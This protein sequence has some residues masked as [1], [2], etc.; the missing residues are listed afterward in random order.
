M[1]VPQLRLLYKERGIPFAGRRLKAELIAGLQD[2]DRRRG[3]APVPIFVQPPPGAGLGPTTPPMIRLPIQPM[4]PAGQ[5]FQLQPAGARPLGPFVPVPIGTLPPA[6]WLQPAPVSPPRQPIP[7]VQ[8]AAPTR[9]VPGARWQEMMGG[10]RRELF[11]ANAPT[12]PY[13]IGLFGDPPIVV[14][15][16]QYVRR[17]LPNVSP[18]DQERLVDAVVLQA[19]GEGIT[20]FDNIA[21]T[22][23]LERGTG[24]AMI[25]RAHDQLRGV[26]FQ[27]PFTREQ[28]AAKVEELYPQVRQLPL[29]RQGALLNRLMYDIETIAWDRPDD[30][31][32][33]QHI[34]VS[35][36]EMIEDTLQ[37]AGLNDEIRGAARATPPAPAARLTDRRA[38]I[39]IE[40][41]FPDLVNLT[42]AQ[43][44]L[45]TDAVITDAD[46]RGVTTDVQFRDYLLA[47]G[48]NFIFP[49]MNDR[50]IAIPQAPAGQGGAP[51]LTRAN[52]EA[53]LEE[54]FPDIRRLDPQA[55]QALVDEV[56]AQ[57]RNAGVGN[58][59]DFRGFLEVELV[60]LVGA[61]LDQIRQQE[62][63][64][65][66]ALREALNREIAR[67]AQGAGQ[68]VPNPAAVN[69]IANLVI[70]DAVRQGVRTGQE[71]VDFLQ[72]FR[73]QVFRDELTRRGIPIGPPLQFRVEQMPF[74][75]LPQAPPELTRERVGTI[76][77]ETFPEVQEL[78]Q[79]DFAALVDHVRTRALEVGVGDEADLHAFL[80]NDGPDLVGIFINQLP[81]QPL[82]PQPA[83]VQLPAP[84]RFVLGPA[85]PNQFPA[86]LAPVPIQLA[87]LP[88]GAAPT[89]I[90]EI[91]FAEPTP[92]LGLQ[93]IY[94]VIN[95]FLVL[96][97]PALSVAG[98][99]FLEQ[100]LEQR[101][102]RAG[103][104][105][106]DAA[107]QT[108]LR[109]L[110]P[111]IIEDR[112]R[113]WTRTGHREFFNPEQQPAPIV[114]L[115]QQAPLRV[116]PG[117][118][119]QFVPAAQLE[120]QR[121]PP[122]NTLEEAAITFLTLHY[123][124]LNATGIRTVALQLAA[125][126][127]G[128]P[129]G[130]N[131][132]V[133]QLWM[134][135][136]GR[137][138][139]EDLVAQRQAIWGAQARLEQLR[140]GR[141]APVAPAQLQGPLD[142]QDII[143][144]IQQFLEREYPMFNRD[145]R[146]RMAG[147]LA[148]FIERERNFI[149]TNQIADWLNGIG[150]RRVIEGH[151]A[152][153]RRDGQPFFTAAAGRAEPPTRAQITDAIDDFLIRRYPEINAQGRI[154]LALE[155][156]P[157][158]LGANET[159]RRTVAAI[160][161]WLEL[162]GGQYIRGK[163]VTWREQNDPYFVAG[164][165]VRQQYQP[166]PPATLPAEV[167]PQQVME[168]IRAFDAD[169]PR[170]EL[171]VRR[172]DV[173]AEQTIPQAQLTARH[174]AEA[175]KRGRVISITID[176][177]TASY[178]AVGYLMTEALPEFI[179]DVAKHLNLTYLND[180]IDVFFNIFWY[181]QQAS[182]ARVMSPS[183]IQYIS[184]LNVDLLKQLLPPNYQGS[185]DRASLLAAL[186]FHARV[187][188]GGYTPERY[189]QVQSYP[190]LAVFYLAQ[191][192]Y[193]D[194]ERRNTNLIPPYIT[195]A[196]N[197]ASRMEP[198]YAATNAQNINQ[199]AERFQLLF[200][201]NTVNVYRRIY[202][203][204]GFGPLYEDF[205]FRTVG[206]VGR[207][208]PPPPLF[209]PLDPNTFDEDVANITIR[210][211]SDR[212]LMDGYEPFE[213][214]DFADRAELL[215]EI[216][217]QAREGARGGAVWT[218]RHHHCNNDDLED[219]IEL[220]PRREVDKN[221]PQN[222]SLS[223]G[224]Q[225]NYRCY[226]MDELMANFNQD[227]DGIFHFY[228]PDWQ[229]DIINPL[230]GQPLEREFPLPAIR[231]LRLL[232]E[233]LALENPVFQPLQARVIE[234]LNANNQAGITMRQLRA[235]Y[236]TL[237]LAD[238][239]SVNEYFTLLFFIGMYLR[240]WNGPGHPY[241]YRIAGDDA[242]RCDDASRD[243][244]FLLYAE[245]RHVLLARLDRANQPLAAWFRALPTINYDW[246][247]GTVRVATPLVGAGR[248]T[249]LLEQ[250]F[251]LL[252]AGNFCQMHGSDIM[253]GSGFFL[254]KEVLEL[255]D[256]TLFNN[257]L[258]QQ[259]AVLNLA[260]AQIIPPRIATHQERIREAKAE[261]DRLTP[262]VN[263]LAIQMTGLETQIRAARTAGQG[264]LVNQLD[265][266]LRELRQQSFA[267]AA[268]R[269]TAKEDEER[270]EAQLAS[271]IYRYGVAVPAQ[272]NQALAMLREMFRTLRATAG[273]K[274]RATYESRIRELGQIVAG[275]PTRLEDFN[276]ARMR[277]TQ[278]E[279]PWNPIQFAE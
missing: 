107:I 61:A 29:D 136:A 182:N 54:T 45:I 153:W 5:Q 206:F 244:N 273:N 150:R 140:G 270:E 236:R 130:Q 201:V 224:V 256:P 55:R 134:G 97:Y 250:V 12:A 221:N 165:Q 227:A 222:P 215:D 95:N 196:R 122:I 24:R 124:I 242:I 118:M 269:T 32:L 272:A 275:N 163:I 116:I 180:T 169:V 274:L 56:R 90:R 168:E 167:G 234:G 84:R 213:L 71:M 139:I 243:G 190:S 99:R 155:L 225:R 229:I 260:L 240:H 261:Y 162:F 3:V 199:L 70:P 220:I 34:E 195:V 253:L 30:D 166:G 159:Y 100:D 131:L 266:R 183:A 133:F 188:A 1:L 173:V 93:D 111:V 23:F 144:Q 212:E 126:A 132:E 96:R 46:R 268:R 78:R 43:Q 263:E 15:T 152:E 252:E 170:A 129:E 143:A 208:P 259:N 154:I 112:I 142:R 101:R 51:Q 2:D 18:Q 68:A 184:R 6:P 57:A 81:A 125:R 210:G 149:T 14:T 279:D 44:D 87:R 25:D 41:A 58:E 211:Y 202:Y 277:I 232:L 94:R 231:T 164:A 52:V 146:F 254:I 179:L 85:V 37:R 74:Q 109:T 28:V 171:R 258:R 207:Y 48:A 219:P 39:L 245:L 82:A 161:N 156:V 8:P 108:W 147:I 230:T 121:N 27:T 49:F 104:A 255:R 42:Q 197:P 21:H 198:V 38:W 20:D 77:R 69:V 17:D 89:G 86:Q 113:E 194:Q 53:V 192:Y 257:F 239:Q 31:A 264:Q 145:G 151:I 226:L 214:D 127:H 177:Q 16:R 59:D 76:L 120:A 115:G 64:D 158:I 276:P 176:G 148:D 103:I 249:H 98:R 102:D 75:A 22:A 35:A 262:Q 119:G 217:K 36:A 267:L 160:L 105:N 251:A 223:Y 114:P 10:A 193:T 141:G 181:I 238:Q 205:L 63:P 187:D 216:I 19:R 209:D 175:I 172:L 241:V 235:F 228:L 92:P 278:H 117:L 4:P 138:L 83:P 185:Q 218:M 247:Q 186:I 237:S 80:E 189:Q 248:P 60:G 178:N 66:P 157:Q 40:S 88:A 11:P 13:D 191:Y 203:F 174:V 7:Q 137:P 233:A 110:A 79:A 265:Q 128:T 47:N 33:E 106:Q 246:E 72:G 65:L 67:V 204:L 200:P 135:R 26:V 62:Q 73:A 123:P 271:D 9:P 91:Q 50:G